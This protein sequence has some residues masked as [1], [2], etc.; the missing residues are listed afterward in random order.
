M[1]SAHPSTYT[2]GVTGY[3]LGHSLSPQL[4]KAAFQS[5]GLQGE[6][7]LYPIP[8]L[9]EGEKDLAVLIDRICT[10]RLDG[11]NVT[12]PHKQAVI[13]HLDRLTPLALQIGA[14]NTIYRQHGLLIGDNTDAPGFM[15]DLRLRFPQA[16]NPQAALVLGSGGSARAVTQALLT[17][18]W[19]VLIAARKPGKAQDILNSLAPIRASSEALQLDV[20]DEYLQS[21]PR[22]AGGA[23][24]LSANGIPRPL[25]LIVNA[26]PLGMF[27]NI[28]GSPW[29]KDLEFPKGVFVYDL[30]YNPSDT[31]LVRAA[32][33]AGLSAASGL[34][35]LIEQA[36]LSFERWTGI[37]PSTEA[38]RQAV[39]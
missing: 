31:L 4:H 33:A 35:M 9:P 21:Q 20:L 2:F 27:P 38:M 6:Y 36:A 18:G 26:T 25:S 8:P 29:P 16:G 3:P 10:H 5:T 22:S 7:R 15:A 1:N 12:I 23:I 39:L 17:A 30:V 11:L 13:R 24:I 19:Q 14:V 37:H 34:G 32:R 28:D